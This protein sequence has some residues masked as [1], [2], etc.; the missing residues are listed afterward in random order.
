MLEGRIVCSYYRAAR[1]AGLLAA[2]ALSA[3]CALAAAHI[4]LTFRR[5]KPT[6]LC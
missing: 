3:L 5:R 4:E 6:K 1:R 2:A